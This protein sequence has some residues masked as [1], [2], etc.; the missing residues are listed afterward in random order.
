MPKREEEKG[1]VMSEQQNA[2]PH[3]HF[4]PHILDRFYA[5][6]EEEP[7]TTRWFWTGD[8]YEQRVVTCLRWTG[9]QHNGKGYGRF[10][11]GDKRWWV[12]SR[13]SYALAHGGHIDDQAE[14]DHL[15]ANPGCV[16]PDHLDAVTGQE[17]LRRAKLYPF[18]WR[19]SPLCRS[20]HPWAGNTRQQRSMRSDGSFGYTRV[21]AQCRRD[22]MRGRYV[23]KPPRQPTT[24]C[25]NGHE[26]TEENTYTTPDGKSRNCIPCNR[27]AVERY[28]ARKKKT[29][30]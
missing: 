25:R 10:A 2:T 4:A 9:A 18:E 20:G 5:K 1:K 16:N 8:R 6:T 12:A 28:H 23:P 7:P 27:Q 26:R 15:C 14:I 19:I 30:R 13:Y 22:D 29:T 21:C 17:N 3:D 11:S 24:H